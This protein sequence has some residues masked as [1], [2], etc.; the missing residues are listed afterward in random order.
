MSAIRAAP[1]V[2][3]VKIAPP[4]LKLATSWL[5]FV[6]LTPVTWALIV[7]ASLSRSTPGLP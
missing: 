6:A 2:I 4:A 1:V 7:S 5:G 3:A